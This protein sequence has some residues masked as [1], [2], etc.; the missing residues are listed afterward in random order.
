[1]SAL[2]NNFENYEPHHS[3]PLLSVA[4]KQ[5]LSKFLVNKLVTRL[6]SAH[7]CLVRKKS[8][9]TQ[10]IAYNGETFIAVDTGNVTVTA[11]FGFNKALDVLPT[12]G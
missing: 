9:V 2:L 11:Y 12:L 8:L 1:M 4:L 5:L 7:H 10:F 6:N 3:L